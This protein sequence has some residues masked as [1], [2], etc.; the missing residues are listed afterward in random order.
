MMGIKM[1]FGCDSV[2]RQNCLW[3]LSLKRRDG[4]RE[5]INRENSVEVQRRE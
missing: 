2:C 4:E 5:R 3:R 1:G